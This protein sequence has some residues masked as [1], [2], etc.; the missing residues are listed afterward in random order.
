MWAKAD[1]PMK[2][3]INFEASSKTPKVTTMNLTTG[4]NRFRLSSE[5][6]DDN[7]NGTVTFYAQDGN[8]V[9]AFYIKKPQLE[10]GK[11]L[12]DYKKSADYFAGKQELNSSVADFKKVTTEIEEE[13]GRTKERM[14]QMNSK[15]DNIDVGV[16]NLV[17]KSSGNNEYPLFLPQDHGNY[18]GGVKKQFY[19]EHIA[20]KCLRHTDAFYQLGSYEKTLRGLEPGKQVTISADVNCESTDYHFEM[21]YTTNAEGNNWRSFVGDVYKELNV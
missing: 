18:D 6:T 16:A 8:E 11:V 19:N 5:V 2:V 1:K 12:S 17:V 10:T 4:W 14:E 3:N 9:T 21:F 7:N 20:M 15:V 13:A